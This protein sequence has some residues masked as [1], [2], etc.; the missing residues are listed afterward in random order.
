MF[1]PPN[2]RTLVV[3]FLVWTEGGR[4]FFVSWI[5]SEKAKIV[6]TTA[7]SLSFCA[8]YRELIYL[9]HNLL[10]QSFGRE[11]RS[12]RL[13]ENVE[14]LIGRVMFWLN[15]TNCPVFKIKTFLVI[16]FFQIMVTYP[17]EIGKFYNLEKFF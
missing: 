1:L 16:I 9:K 15:E 3:V 11:G 14:G 4:F 5:S 7:S 17:S 8:H 13:L 10:T 2:V 6:H 12:L